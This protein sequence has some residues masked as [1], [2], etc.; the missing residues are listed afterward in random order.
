[1]GNLLLSIRSLK[2]MLEVNFQMK[3]CK[4]IKTVSRTYIYRFAKKNAHLKN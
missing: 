3:K 1:M 2:L 4:G